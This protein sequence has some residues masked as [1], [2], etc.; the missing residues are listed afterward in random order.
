MKVGEKIVDWHIWKEYPNL[1]SHL[2]ASR[3]GTVFLLTAYASV[4]HLK[5]VHTQ[6]LHKAAD[7]SAS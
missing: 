7:I 1:G 2:K 4:K 6:L 3:N 5:V